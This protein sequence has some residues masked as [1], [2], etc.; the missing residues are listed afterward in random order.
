MNLETASDAAKIPGYGAAADPHR[1][2]DDE[3]LLIISGQH[4]IEIVDGVL[5]HYL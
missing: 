2:A 1:I 3:L 4:Q 5:G